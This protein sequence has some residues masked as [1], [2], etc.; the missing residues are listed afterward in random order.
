M[1]LVIIKKIANSNYFITSEGLVW[2]VNRCIF[3]KATRPKSGYSGVCLRVNNKTVFRT[4]HSLVAEAFVPNPENKPQVNH[5]DGNKT[6]NHV[7][8]LEWVTHSENQRHAINIGIKRFPKGSRVYNSKLTEAIVLRAR[9]EYAQGGVTHAKLAKKYG[10]S[11]STMTMAINK[12]K[13]RHI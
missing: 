13:W 7:D 12:T 4:V 1:S 3:L 10:V 9:D 6:N 5:I 2:S 11:Q 8:N